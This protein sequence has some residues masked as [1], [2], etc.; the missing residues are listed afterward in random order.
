MK[1]YGITIK[2]DLLDPKHIENM[3]IAVWLYMWL[4]DKMTKI[5]DRKDGQVLGGK[6]ITYQDVRNDLGIGRSTYFRWLQALEDG[7]YIT[8][9]R[10]P[11]GVTVVLHKA[12][13]YYGNQVSSAEKRV[14]YVG[15]QSPVC[16]TRCTEYGTRC[17]ECEPSNK[18][19]QDN[20]ED[21]TT[22]AVRKKYS[23][24]GA[25]V[26][27]EFEEVDPKN[28]TYYSNKTQRGA[29]DFLIEE[30]GLEKVTAVIRLLPK[31]NKQP[32]FPSINSP[33]DLKEKWAKLEAAL[34][35]KKQQTITNGRGL[36]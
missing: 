33:N 12:K 21:N 20:T 5:N 8:C 22:S 2:N 32:Y 24:L 25:E 35:R 17:T 31:T 6:P 29:C 28:K 1:G 7:Q 18:T 34:V 36:A 16:G 13:K 3:G 23:S 27:K 9:N 19:I 4:L 11:K 15:Q 14:P 10:T 30:Y 26:L